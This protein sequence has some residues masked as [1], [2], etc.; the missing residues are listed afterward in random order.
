MNR[1][2]WVRR[3]SVR[4]QARQWESQPLIMVNVHD[5][6]IHGPLPVEPGASP[7]T[8]SRRRVLAQRLLAELVGPPSRVPGH[9]LLSAVS[10]SIPVAQLASVERALSDVS[11]VP[12]RSPESVLITAGAGGTAARVHGDG[13]SMVFRFSPQIGPVLVL[14]DELPDCAVRV[15][16]DP[17]RDGRN[18]VRAAVLGVLVGAGTV[19]A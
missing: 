14:V 10:L 5:A 6:A 12:Q 8:V 2:M 4:E 11:G 18:R 19:V 15:D 3:R 17:D 13:Y 1:W 9:D 7:S 16:T